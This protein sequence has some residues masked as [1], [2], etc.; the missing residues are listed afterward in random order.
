MLRW[1][2]GRGKSTVYVD[3]HDVAVLHDLGKISPEFQ[4]GPEPVEQAAVAAESARERF[5]ETA[6]QLRAATAP[7]ERRLAARAFLAALAELV[8]CLLRFLVAVLLLLLSRL[9]GSA[10]ADELPTWKPDPIETAPQIAP[11]GPN[12]AFPVNINR[13][14]RRRSALGSAVLAA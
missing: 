2:V 13:G 4:M 11:R 5:R 14:G 3:F 12:P 9:Q 6:E 7:A 10:T 1:W 8:A